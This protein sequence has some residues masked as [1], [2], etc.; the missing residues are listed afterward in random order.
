MTLI[1]NYGLKYKVIKRDN[2]FYLYER[3]FNTLSKKNK[4]ILIL[5]GLKNVN[6]FI[7]NNNLRKIQNLTYEL[8]TIEEVKRLEKK[9]KT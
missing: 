6:T 4:Y 9:E 2:E 1:D 3:V 5:T 8:K 7:K